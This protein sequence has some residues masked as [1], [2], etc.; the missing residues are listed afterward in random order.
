[1]L[2]L[3][4]IAEIEGPAYGSVQGREPEVSNVQ[5]MQDLYDA[6]GRGDIPI[7]L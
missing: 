6:F 5:L 7:E 1:M 2:R 4:A 3:L